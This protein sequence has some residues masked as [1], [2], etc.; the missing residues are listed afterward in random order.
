MSLS[1]IKSLKWTNFYS[2]PRSVTERK[3]EHVKEKIGYETSSSVLYLVLD[4]RRVQGELTCSYRTLDDLA[5]TNKKCRKVCAFYTPSS[6]VHRHKFEIVD[7]I[8]ISPKRGDFG[9]K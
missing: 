9:Q 4:Q 5:H 1:R 7:E 8:L 2:E 3:T 6:K